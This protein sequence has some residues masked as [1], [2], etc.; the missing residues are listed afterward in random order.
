LT[1]LTVN[2]GKPVGLGLSAYEFAADDEQ[3]RIEFPHS[4]GGDTSSLATALITLS[5][6]KRAPS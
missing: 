4:T 6:S 2:I 5:S 3:R 1:V